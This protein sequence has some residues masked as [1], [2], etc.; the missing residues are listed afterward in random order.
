M[1]L[2]G[3]AVF[4]P[5]QK[6]QAQIIDAIEEIIKEAIMAVDLGVQKIQTQTVYLQDA[7]KAV[8]NAMQQLHLDDITSWVQQ[9]KDLYGEYYQELW[10]IKTAISTYQRVKD[11]IR[12]Q[13]QIVSDYN[14][15]YGLLRKDPHFSPAEI[16]HMYNI[17]SGMLNQ[18]VQNIAQLT[19][20]ITAF[21]TQMS[22][23]DRLKLI[24]GVG[25]RVDQNYSDLHL[26]TQQNIRMSLER[27]RDASDAQEIKALYGIQ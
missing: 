26:Y 12:K 23:G 15:A 3:V 20:V 7:Q 21:I 16:T 25:S 10:Q 24:D 9:Q 11:I 22:D 18:S 1:L 6:T 4:A 2:A 19:Q 13:E 27:A 14:T 8:E 17:Y 5:V